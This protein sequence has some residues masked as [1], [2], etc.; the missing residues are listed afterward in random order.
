M[1]LKKGNSIR[2][3][4]NRKQNHD[5]SNSEIAQENVK[6]RYLVTESESE[7]KG[8]HPQNLSSY[9][10]DGDCLEALPLI[11]KD[12]KGCFRIIYIDPP[13]NTGKQFTYRDNSTAEDW[14]DF[15][16]EILPQ[17][18]QLLRDDGLIFIIC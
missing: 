14:L 11:A 10:I 1:A 17:A 2:L 7:V 15:M 6:D 8:L 13:Y 16:S 9:L 5:G 18:R 4:W 12:M 3:T